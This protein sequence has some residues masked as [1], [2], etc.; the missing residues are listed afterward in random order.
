MKKEKEYFFSGDWESRR[1]AIFYCCLIL[2]GWCFIMV[3]GSIEAVFDANIPLIG[4]FLIWVAFSYIL[5]KACD[6]IAYRIIKK[7]EKQV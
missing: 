1:P 4:S 5:F 6:F 2:G 7:K 3:K